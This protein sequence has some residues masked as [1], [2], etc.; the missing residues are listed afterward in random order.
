MLV[1]IIYYCQLLLTLLPSCFALYTLG[2][3]MYQHDVSE[4]VLTDK[5]AAVVQDCVA[6]VGV[7]LNTASEH[8]LRY[9]SGYVALTEVYCYKQRYSDCATASQ[10]VSIIIHVTT[11][12]R[13]SVF[14]HHN[15]ILSS[16]AHC[17]AS[18]PLGLLYFGNSTFTA[19]CAASV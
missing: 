19:V 13:C 15:C 17:L 6:D 7:E 12:S 1:V 4:G 3:G 8:L 9:V 11:L 16:C 5:L 10:S 2:L 14:D 18:I